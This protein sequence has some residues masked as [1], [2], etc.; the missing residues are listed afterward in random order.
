MTTQSIHN[1]RYP[2]CARAQKKQDLLLV[3]SFALW[4]A[5]LGFSPVLAFRLLL[6]S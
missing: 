2:N 4:A 1:A 6:G 5:L 3:S